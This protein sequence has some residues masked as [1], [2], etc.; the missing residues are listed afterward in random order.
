MGPAPCSLKSYP[1]E[2]QALAT[3]GGL[4]LL[5]LNYSYKLKNFAILDKHREVD[6]EKQA[7]CGGSSRGRECNTVSTVPR[8]RVEMHAEGGMFFMDTVLHG[9]QPPMLSSIIYTS[10]YI[11]SIVQSETCMGGCTVA[12][13]T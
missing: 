8:Q 9:I 3:R 4:W 10:I 11:S 13:R 7:S 2:K 5:L 1:L 6:G 12:T